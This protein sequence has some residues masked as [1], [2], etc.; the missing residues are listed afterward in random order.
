MS[1]KF[2]PKDFCLHGVGHK[3]F[4]VQT[5]FSGRKKVI[6]EHFVPKSIVD[7]INRPAI[8]SA[9]KSYLVV[10]LYI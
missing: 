8:Y 5:A 2:R 10:S 6:F 3:R 1:G 7:L 4:F 9:E